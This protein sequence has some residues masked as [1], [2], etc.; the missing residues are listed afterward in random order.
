MTWHIVEGRE[1][2]YTEV[3]IPPELLQ[4]VPHKRGNNVTVIKHDYMS[5]LRLQSRGLV[6][7]GPIAHYDF[8]GPREPFIHQYVTAD[9]LTR[10]PKAFCFNGLGC[11][12][13]LSALWAMDYLRKQGIVKRILIVAPWAV[14]DTAWVPELFQS[15]PYLNTRLLEGTAE[16]KR[17]NAVNPQTD[18]VM[19]NPESAHIIADYV[20]KK[21]AFDLVIVD[22]S[23]K[24]KNPSTRRWKA[25]KKIA[26]RSRYLWLMT[27]TPTP[28]SP[29]DAYGQIRLVRNKYLSARAWKGLTMTQIS[30]FKWVPKAGASKTIAE[31]MQPAVWYKRED[32]P[33][34]PDMP[35]P[36]TLKVRLSKE[37]QELSDKLKD[38]ALAM[39]E[40]GEIRA[41]NAAAIMT[42]L[43]QVQCGGVYAMDDTGDNV[44]HKV[45]SKPFFTAV[46]DFIEQA[47]TM[48][49]TLASFRASAGMI[50]ERLQKSGYRVALYHG[51]VPK[52]ERSDILRQAR[53]GNLDALVAVPS[54]MSH[55]VDGLQD[56]ARFILWTSPPTSSETYHQTNGRLVRKGQQNKVVLAHIITSPLAKDLYARLESRQ[57]LESA[58][59]DYIG[60]G[61]GH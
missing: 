2:A 57:R 41:P 50:Y 11:G 44:T 56:S 34:M 29:E 24:F 59:L 5:W 49:L 31:W 19:V 60:A 22:E 9:F 61:N 26:D 17:A 55:G 53:K 1:A 6:I 28:Q 8:P 23:T 20:V 38:E 58:V 4:G 46:E 3:A 14:L 33:D 21:G 27:G 15:T 32:C 25:L 47:D 12:K 54:T 40:G 7:P 37:Q 42:K 36:I 45:P 51:D 30:R 52:A 48:V 16:K 35:A 43:L 18:V 10:N 39:V 13:T